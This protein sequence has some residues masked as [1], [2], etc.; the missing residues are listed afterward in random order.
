M[1][2]KGLLALIAAIAIC[3]II[4]SAS[5][6]TS[7]TT[8]QSGISISGMIRDDHGN[9]ISGATVTLYNGNIINKQFINS[10]IVD[11]LN[12]PQM[13]SDSPIK[14]MFV[15]TSLPKGEY[16]IT[17]EKDGYITSQTLIA[18]GIGGTQSPII[19]LSGYGEKPSTVVKPSTTTQAT[20]GQDLSNNG[21][22]SSIFPPF[23]DI[24]R[25]LAMA[26]I[27]AQLVFCFVVLALFA[28]TRK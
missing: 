5:Y 20:P 15:F 11:T 26:A 8:V 28:N 7:Q 6:A 22:Q 16:N 1:S 10:N 9:G 4:F 2:R 25:I 27:G 3:F 18:D 21:D 13:T 14:G 17:V 19:I 23:Y 24:I 12:N